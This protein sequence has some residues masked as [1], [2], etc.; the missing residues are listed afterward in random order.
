MARRS[1]R[2][3]AH[4]LLPSLKMRIKTRSHANDKAETP[5]IQESKN[6]VLDDDTNDGFHEKRS[7][8]ASAVHC[9]PDGHETGSWVWKGQHGTQGSIAAT[10]D[11]ETDDELEHDHGMEHETDIVTDIVTDKER[12]DS[13]FNPTIPDPIRPIDAEAEEKSQ[14]KVSASSCY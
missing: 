6:S 10:L 12:P 13:F 8:D 3:L 5:E 14:I 9:D 7:P 1:H 4:P 2:L 11:P